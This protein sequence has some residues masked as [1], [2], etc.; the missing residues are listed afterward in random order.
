M[1]T[2]HNEAQVGEIAKTVLMPGDPLRAQF[3]AQTYL[4]DV[5]QFNTVRNMLGFTGTYKGKKVSI[6]GS[7]MG[8]PSIGIYC[9]ELYSQYGVETIIRIGSCG[10]LQK[11]V[12]L[13]DIIIAQGACT[14]SRFA[15]Q[16]ELPGTF[17]AISS[18]HLLE[19][20]V[21]QAKEKNVVY[22]VGNIISSDIFYHFDK[23]SSEKWASMGCLGVEMESY[24]LFATAAYFHKHAITLLT[25]SDSLVTNEVTTAKERENTFTAMME[26][27]LEI[28]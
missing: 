15:H 11:D 17:S 12:H 6:M 24:A 27:A 21:E 1:S 28:A 26:I 5:H 7:G 20:A 18:Y 9:Y 19:K 13:R 10:G 4:E 8:I 25:V 16:F 14:D 23:G 3:L 22:H 2:P